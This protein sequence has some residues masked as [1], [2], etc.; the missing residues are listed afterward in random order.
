MLQYKFSFITLSLA[1]TAM[2]LCGC[3]HHAAPTQ[4][5]PAKVDVMVLGSTTTSGGSAATYSGTVSSDEE[6]VVSFSVPGTI[7]DIFVKEGERVA[8]GQTLARVKGESLDDEREIAVAE[9]EQVQDLYNRLKKLHDQN[10][11]P[12]VKWVEVQAK[13]KQAKSAV[14]LADRAVGDA[15]ITAP[16]AGYVTEKLADEGQSVIPAQPVLK[17]T[18]IADLQIAI[19]VA[20]ED[21]SRFGKAATATVTFDALD[22]LTLQAPMASKD[23]VADPFTRSYKVKFRIPAEADGRVL[24]GM[25]GTVTVSGLDSIT[26]AQGSEVT[27]FVVPSQAVLLTADNRQFVWIVDGGKALR[28]YVEADEL[29]P[30]GVIVKNGLARGDSVIVAGMQKVGEGSA[31]SVT[32]K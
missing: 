3:K 5:P 9:L 4:A 26:G 10:A 19:P 16:F 29:H 28:R 27:N 30:A 1:V 15:T 25:I 31:V 8:K 22:G 18:D 2:M 13:L 32:I 23:V 24:P 21:I 7:S 12:D 17:I 14:A 20:E 6:S 11:L